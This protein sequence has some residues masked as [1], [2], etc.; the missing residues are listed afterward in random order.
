MNIT[1]TPA[2]T[3]VAGMRE[4]RLKA[5]DVMAAFLARIAE[6]NPL[7]NAIISLRPEAELMAEARLRD[8][9]AARGALHGL[10]IAIKDLALT[11]GLRTTFGS[12]IFKD[13]VPQEDDLFVARIR[14]AGAIIIGKTNTPEWGLGSQ[15]YNPLFGTT[16]NALD[17]ALA[18]GG[19]S[20]GAAVAVALG[21]LAMADGSDMGGS[22]RNPAGWN[23]IYGLRPS[24]GRV[25]A[26]GDED[27][28]FAQLSTEGPMA[29]HPQD[30]ALLLS[31][32][33]GH[34]LHAPLSRT[35]RVSTE[36]VPRQGRVG[37]IANIGEHM[38]FEAGVIEASR[39]RRDMQ[40]IRVD[41]D[42]EALWQA[43]KVLRQTSTGSSLRRHYD[44]PETRHL[45]KPE[46][47]WEVEQSL[48]LT[49]ADVYAASVLR[50]R[51][52]RHVLALLDEYDAIALP[53]AQVFAFPA[54]IHWP[55][56]IAGVK[57]DSYHRWMQVVTP[58][59]LSGMPVLAEPA[60]HD[61]QGRAMGLQLIG[62]PGGEMELL[63][64]AAGL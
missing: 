26:P 13:L 53:T 9:Q 14:D 11:K 27:Q 62:R 60:G 38:P 8:Q 19:S 49:A 46:A 18:A 56:E 58:G 22:L 2:A 43:F 36:I 50:T 29:R 63:G 21:M 25:P 34:H 1:A 51:W 31:V 17:P 55:D 30:L 41:F 57:M 48:K 45:L 35:D 37:F 52:Y 39:A 44:N 61:R 24:Q 12:P 15:S 64:L 10:P 3:L 42:F 54:S 6:K 40:D 4:G 47:Q 16:R 23:G 5:V 59:T 28:F 20:G 33:A 7:H 32:M